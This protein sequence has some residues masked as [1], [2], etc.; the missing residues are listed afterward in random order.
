M[1]PQTW[2]LSQPEAVQVMVRLFGPEEHRRHPSLEAW[3]FLPTPLAATDLTTVAIDTE[4]EGRLVQ[5][6]TRVRSWTIT[7]HLQECTRPHR[8]RRRQLLRMTLTAMIAA[9]AD[10]QGHAH[11]TR[12]DAHA[13]AQFVDLAARALDGQDPETVNDPPPSAPSPTAPPMVDRTPTMKPTTPQPD[14]APRANPTTTPPTNPPTASVTNPTV[15]PTNAPTADA[16]ALTVVLMLVLARVHGRHANS[17][18]ACRVA[19]GAFLAGMMWLWR[20]YRRPEVMAWMCYITLLRVTRQTD[21]HWLMWM[22]TTPTNVRTKRRIDIGRYGPCSLLSDCRGSFRHYFP[23]HDLTVEVH[24]CQVGLILAN[25]RETSVFLDL[26]EYSR[27]QGYNIESVRSRAKGAMTVHPEQNWGDIATHPNGGTQGRIMRELLRSKYLLE[28]GNVEAQRLLENSGDAELHLPVGSRW[29][30]GRGGAGLFARLMS[31]VRQEYF[32]QLCLSS[33]DEDDPIYIGQDVPMR[34]STVSPTLS[35]KELAAYSPPSERPKDVT[36]NQPPH[37]PQCPAPPAPNPPTS[38]DAEP[39][40]HRDGAGGRTSP[41]TSNPSLVQYHVG[42]DDEIDDEKA[43]D[44]QDTDADVPQT[45]GTL[46]PL[47]E[48]D[49]ADSPLRHDTADRSSTLLTPPR[50]PKAVDSTVDH[51]TPRR[52]SRQEQQTLRPLPPTPLTIKGAR[53][54]PKKH[55]ECR[56]H[57]SAVRPCRSGNQC[58]FRHN[59]STAERNRIRDNRLKR[60]PTVG[61]YPPPSKRPKHMTPNQPPRT[62]QRPTRKGGGPRRRVTF[63]DRAPNDARHDLTIVSR[64]L[65]PRRGSIVLPFRVEVSAQLSP[66]ALASIQHMLF[67]VACDWA[68]HDV[69]SVTVHTT[70]VGDGSEVA[71]DITFD[72]DYDNKDHHAAL[73]HLHLNNVVEHIVRMK[74]LATHPNP[75]MRLETRGP[76]SP[77]TS[78]T[79]SPELRMESKGRLGSDANDTNEDTSQQVERNSRD[80]PHRPPSSRH[81]HPV[82]HRPVARE[83]DVHQWNTAEVGAPAALPLLPNRNAGIRNNGNECWGAAVCQAMNHDPSLGP[84]AAVHQENTTDIGRAVQAIFR[85]LATSTLTPVDMGQRA[86]TIRPANGVTGDME[87]VVETMQQVITDHSTGVDA[88][89]IAAAHHVYSRQIIVARRDGE[90]NVDARTDP[91]IGISTVRPDLCAPLHAQHQPTRFVDLLNTSFAGEAFVGSNQ[92]VNSRDE[93]VDADGYELISTL[94]DALTITINRHQ[95]GTDAKVQRQVTIT[96]CVVLSL[97][98]EDHLYLVTAVVLHQGTGVNGG[99]YTSVVRTRHPTEPYTHYDDDAT[100]HY[101]TLPQALEAASS[102]PAGLPRMAPHV[103]MATRVT[104]RPKDGTLPLEEDPPADKHRTGPSPGSGTSVSMGDGVGTTGTKHR[105]DPEPDALPNAKRTRSRSHTDLG[106]RSTPLVAGRRQPPVLGAQV[107]PTHG[108]R[109][110]AADRPDGTASPTKRPRHSPPLTLKQYALQFGQIVGDPEVLEPAVAGPVLAL[111]NV[112]G[113]L[114]TGTPQTPDGKRTRLQAGRL[115][116]RIGQPAALIAAGHVAVFHVNE[117]Q[118]THPQAAAVRTVMRTN[119]PEVEA[120]VHAPTPEATQV[121]TAISSYCT[122]A[123]LRNRSA[124][125]ATGKQ[126]PPILRSEGRVTGAMYTEGGHVFAVVGAKC[127]P[128]PPSDS[129]TID[130]DGARKDQSVF[131]ALVECHRYYWTERQ[132][133]VFFMLDANCVRDGI[134]R[135]AGVLHAYDKASRH[136]HPLRF[137]VDECGGIDYFRAKHPQTPAMTYHHTGTGSASRVD[138][139]VGIGTEHDY[140]PE[141]CYVGLTE[142]GPNDHGVMYL[143]LCAPERTAACPIP[144]AEVDLVRSMVNMVR[145]HEEDRMLKAMAC[146]SGPRSPGSRCRAQLLAL[147]AAT[148]VLDSEGT[149]V[150][151]HRIQLAKAKLMLHTNTL[152]VVTIRQHRDKAPDYAGLS[153]TDAAEAAALLERLI[154]KGGDHVDLGPARQRVRT[155]MDEAYLLTHNLPR[156]VQHSIVMARPRPGSSTPPRQPTTK[157]QTALTLLSRSCRTNQRHTRLT[158]L[159]KQLGLP[160]PP[161]QDETDAAWTAWEF[162]AS[163]QEGTRSMLRRSIA[164]TPG[165]GSHGISRGST[166][167][168]K[169]SHPQSI[170]KEVARMWPNASTM[171]SPATGVARAGQWIDAPEQAAQAA[172]ATLTDISRDRGR[173][174]NQ[175]SATAALHMICCTEHLDEEGDV[176]LRMR[177]DFADVR[178]R[179]LNH[180]H[181]SETVL[182][183]L[184]QWAAAHQDDPASCPDECLIKEVEALGYVRLK[185]RTTAWSWTRETIAEIPILI[186]FVERE[187]A[188]VHTVFTS[189]HAMTDEQLHAW[190]DYAAGVRDV[191]HMLQLLGCVAPKRSAMIPVE[192]VRMGGPEYHQL[193]FALVQLVSAGEVTPN[194]LYTQVTLLYK[195]NYAMKEAERQIAIGSLLDLIAGIHYNECLA[196]TIGRAC[197]RTNHGGIPGR[198]TDSAKVAISISVDHAVAYDMAQHQDKADKTAAF[199]TYGIKVNSIYIWR[200]GAAWWIGT[201]TAKIL[202]MYTF[203]VQFANAT[204]R[205]TGT[206]KS[207]TGQGNQSSPMRHNSTGCCETTAV[208]LLR[209]DYPQYAFYFDGDPRI[210][211]AWAKMGGRDPPPVS[212]TH[213][214]L[215]DGGRRELFPRRPI[216]RSSSG[217]PLAGR[218]ASRGPAAPMSLYLDDVNSIHAENGDTPLWQSTLQVVSAVDVF[219]QC[220]N[221]VSKFERAST[222]T[223]QAQMGNTPWNIQVTAAG[224]DGRLRRQRIKHVANP[225]DPEGT[226]TPA[227]GGS[228]MLGVVT[229]F[230]EDAAGHNRNHITDLTLK[231]IHQRFVQNVHRPGV[232]PAVAT[233]AAGLIHHGQMA[234]TQTVRRSPPGQVMKWDEDIARAILRKHRLDPDSVPDTTVLFIER[235]HG[236]LG[237]PSTY[238]AILIAT[239][240]TNQSINNDKLD[241]VRGLYRHAVTATHPSFRRPGKPP[242]S[243]YSSFVEN[244]ALWYHANGITTHRRPPRALQLRDLAFDH[245]RDTRPVAPSAVAGPRMT[246]DDYRKRCDM[247]MAQPGIL[248]YVL[249]DTEATARCVRMTPDGVD[250]SVDYIMR[251]SDEP[252]VRASTVMC[253]RSFATAVAACSRHQRPTTIVALSEASLRTDNHVMCD[254]T[255]DHE[256]RQLTPAGL[257]VARQKETVLLDVPALP[258]TDTRHILGVVNTAAHPEAH[259]AG[260]TVM[261]PFMNMTAAAVDRLHRQFQQWHGKMMNTERRQEFP[262]MPLSMPM[263]AL[264]GARYV[265]ATDGGTH[266]GPDPT[267][268]PTAAAVLH[269]QRAAHDAPLH[270]PPDTLEPVRHHADVLH[271][272]LTQRPDNQYYLWVH[273]P[274]QSI[275]AEDNTPLT[276]KVPN[277]HLCAAQCPPKKAQQGARTVRLDLLCFRD[278]TGAS[279]DGEGSVTPIGRLEFIDLLQ[280]THGHLERVHAS[281]HPLLDLSKATPKTP[282]P[283]LTVNVAATTSRSST[284][285]H[286]ATMVPVAVQDDGM[287][288]SELSDVPDALRDPE[289]A[290]RKAMQQLQRCYQIHGSAEIRRWFTDGPMAQHMSGTVWAAVAV[291]SPTFPLTFRSAHFALQWHSMTAHSEDLLEPR[292]DDHRGPDCYCTIFGD[293]AECSNDDHHSQMNMDRRRQAQQEATAADDSLCVEQTARWICDCGHGEPTLMALQVHVANAP[294][295]EWHRRSLDLYTASG[296]AWVLYDTITRRVVEAGLVRVPNVGDEDSDSTR[297]EHHGAAAGVLNAIAKLPQDATVTLWADNKGMLDRLDSWANW[298]EHVTARTQAKMSHSAATNCLYTVIESAAL[299]FSDGWLTWSW[300]GC[301]HDVAGVARTT[302][303]LTNRLADFGATVSAMYAHNDPLAHCAELNELS[304]MDVPEHYLC[305]RGCP[306]L[307]KVA[308]RLKQLVSTRNVGRALGTTS[309]APAHMRLTEAFMDGTANPNATARVR[310]LVRPYV[311]DYLDRV[312][313]AAHPT[314][315]AN[316]RH[317]AE[318][319][320]ATAGKELLLNLQRAA[321]N[322]PHCDHQWDRP[323]SLQDHVQYD[324]LHFGPHRAQAA[325]ARSALLAGVGRALWYDQ[326]CRHR[327]QTAQRRRCRGG[328]GAFASHGRD[329]PPGCK[330][331]DDGR[332]V[333]ATDGHGTPLEAD[334]DWLDWLHALLPEDVNIS[335]KDFL[336]EAATIAAQMSAPDGE[337]PQADRYVLHPLMHWW[338]GCQLKTQWDWTTPPQHQPLAHHPT[339]WMPRLR[340]MPGVVAEALRLKM[341]LSQYQSNAVSVGIIHGSPSEVRRRMA[342]MRETLQGRSAVVI[343]VHDQTELSD[344]AC[345]SSMASALPITV[346]ATFPAGTYWTRTLRPNK[347]DEPDE[348]DNHDDGNDNTSA[349]ST[350][351]ATKKRERRWPM[352]GCP[353]RDPRSP[354]DAAQHAASMLWYAGCA[355]GAAAI[356][357]V[358]RKDIRELAYVLAGSNPTSTIAGPKAE[359]KLYEGGN[360]KPVGAHKLSL[361]DL[362]QQQPCD[363]RTPGLHADWTLPCTS[364]R[365][366]SATDDE[367][368]DRLCQARSPRHSGTMS[369]VPRGA[370]PT[371]VHE[372]LK[373]TGLTEAAANHTA[374]QLAACDATNAATLDACHHRRVQHLL[375]IAGCPC[376]GG[377]DDDEHEVQACPRCNNTV[378][379]TFRDTVRPGHRQSDPEHEPQCF[380][381]YHKGLTPVQLLQQLRGLSSDSE[382]T[383]HSDPDGGRT[384]GSK[385]AR[386]GPTTRHSRDFPV[387]PGARLVRNQNRGEH[388]VVTGHRPHHRTRTTG[389]PNSFYWVCPTMPLMSPADADRHM[390]RRTLGPAS[391]CC[392]T[393]WEVPVQKF[394]AEPT[395]EAASLQARRIAAM[396]TG[397]A[398][399][400]ASASS[401]PDDGTATTA[402]AAGREDH[403]RAALTTWA[404]PPPGETSNRGRNR[405]RTR[406][407]ET[408]EATARLCGEAEGHSNGN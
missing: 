28:G 405:G 64:T 238:N 110:P 109:N 240:L 246:D 95:R 271:R 133:P 158:T 55:R 48:I 142:K 1:T 340:G 265:L 72:A 112:G 149:A 35:D 280:A 276:W 319:L 266:D 206:T 92:W 249:T 9:T 303:Q 157:A 167:Q 320:T 31:E 121:S 69:K 367:A 318:G 286:P 371:N 343:V 308:P 207:G 5:V 193:L 250:R 381:C 44:D 119:Y 202:R 403:T 282:H 406:P 57:G 332:R 364:P 13:I 198:S 397:D 33:G 363:P 302:V 349:D 163:N 328:T 299:H 354:A 78:A 353:L 390:S 269:R 337:Q 217:R 315:W 147:T 306:V 87:C 396:D 159:M 63:D 259:S 97:G 314:E 82:G 172:L 32:S 183:G 339:P 233:A 253:T 66:D 336:I 338:M 25:V 287:L 111:T 268:S 348:D 175:S 279:E 151:W 380:M 160:A 264:K 169:P 284:L 365:P 17:A 107:E 201:L 20:D 179:A 24:S 239:V 141:H 84:S 369:K 103:I 53:H 138:I 394:L 341:D 10:G 43:S 118:L 178:E 125:P 283:R 46:R 75:T 34:Q 229:M 58:S 237:V 277:W 67:G 135:R 164:S 166:F 199:N 293:D 305:I 94:P 155:A 129:T 344:V 42:P 375:A 170:G 8:T 21:G 26:V 262:L 188:A 190:E 173:G 56:Y 140:P 382:P 376:T 185:D 211:R 60:P 162:G 347:L 194:V 180:R 294:P 222:R 400:D 29:G 213:A 197:D 54:S 189:R 208:R 143:K 152:S 182:Q 329:L 322:C 356:P 144:R 248:Y 136:H 4:V 161:A 401:L 342:A 186:E 289:R 80:S 52:Q 247:A 130:L 333:Q 254:L 230:G 214:A 113:G 100:S 204:P 36:P 139:I 200:F 50:L 11:W 385:G 402:P 168:T 23:Q 18:T 62:P 192:H 106:P 127:Q 392:M 330:W 120:I 285:W 88:D 226:D 274:E 203:R 96:E 244:G 313:L 261:G 231:R 355:D 275:L 27:T 324:C 150:P 137:L 108:A 102:S 148:Q 90:T 39:A 327:L 301:E 104:K 378:S 309:Q 153:P 196:L 124:L 391:A 89:R 398:E 272:L 61:A 359:W 255:T 379:R 311:R 2:S 296:A 243:G 368:W 187:L 16:A 70:A 156:E 260:G 290:L 234:N 177:L 7:T 225:G 30:N 218:A 216:R 263:T 245:A 351:L 41:Q 257:K 51:D 297:G 76:E 15:L 241:P 221:N 345:Y 85:E 331:S 128:A 220:I 181:R 307:S 358:T 114:L 408:R 362:P 101:K 335:G 270:M 22:P 210:T 146:T 310:T 71:V 316:L 77:P 326:A 258:L 38:S 224:A 292:L 384:V 49:N 288:H 86:E 47:H 399:D 209:H 357:E 171:G 91:T 126:L 273:L 74:T 404:A 123:L 242:R 295:G 59:A 228:K 115:S 346:M 73:R 387:R 395:P 205:A 372:L 93:A 37:T 105:N 195:P 366:A 65:P 361:Q 334:V 252:A 232:S 256:A 325:L 116:E 373:M 45:A 323:M 145:P 79:P 312:L 212:T 81:G 304:P 377:V 184:K 360:A 389:K 370:V 407:R 393:A 191:E 165:N 40:Q 223:A 350:P 134:D 3:V 176:Q 227:R 122:T 317:H 154:P 19:C 251:H 267:E 374:L 132:V 174:A 131:R 278:G 388:V 236:G 12:N 68:D 83:H 386:P 291:D 99:H 298:K 281:R 321:F 219:M 352:P 14:H 117:C 383:Q 235:E 6:R 98:D 215:P 300:D